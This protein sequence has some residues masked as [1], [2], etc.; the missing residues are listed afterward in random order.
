MRKLGMKIPS[1]EGQDSR[2]RLIETLHLQANIWDK[3]N[4]QQMQKMDVYVKHLDRLFSMMTLIQKNEGSTL[5]A[6]HNAAKGA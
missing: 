1:L 4:K 2:M 3:D 6:A 5:K